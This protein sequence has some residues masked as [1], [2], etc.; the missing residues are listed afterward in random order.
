MDP[1]KVI[2][3][4]CEDITLEDVRNAIKEGYTSW[5]Q[6]KRVLRIGMG[7]CGGK[8]CRILVLRELAQHLNVPIDEVKTRPT[9]VRPPLRAT[10]LKV[11]AKEGK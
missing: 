2:I 8:T 11:F 7:P 3:C 4:R 1:K 9:V 5:D 6:L 10:P